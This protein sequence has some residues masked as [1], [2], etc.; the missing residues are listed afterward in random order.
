MDRPHITALVPVGQYHSGFLTKAIGSVLSQTS[1]SWRLLVIGDQD[2]ATALAHLLENELSDP[3]IKMLCGEKDQLAHK[4]NLG[5]KR[6]STD[7]VAILLGDDMWSHNAVEVL[8]RYIDRYPSADLL[9]SSRIFIDE[10]DRA[11]SSVHHSRERITLED[12]IVTSPVKHLICW[13]T[14]KALALGGLDETINYVGPDDY[15]FPWTMA[16]AGAVFKSIGE[17]L[18]LHRDHRECYR[19]TTHVPRSWQIRETRRIMQKHGAA[20]ADIRRRIAEAKRSYLRQ[21]LYR[22]SL[23]KWLKDRLGSDPR[24]GWR[25]AYR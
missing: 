8:I 10:H 3:R 18:Y 16:Q 6:A 9:H 12:F 7:F 1:S 21:C 13:R 17:C 4:L 14:S 24:K 20:R 19:L 2:N 22:S 5:M 25:S 23:D 11:I 15:D